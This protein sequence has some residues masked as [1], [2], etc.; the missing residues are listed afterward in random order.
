MLPTERP[1]G[2]A[3]VIL[4]MSPREAARRALVYRQRRAE[5]PRER[6]L[7]I[8]AFIGTL[9]VH[10]LVL[11]GAILGPA[12]DMIEPARQP[13]EPLQV[14]L[15]AHAPEPPPPP[16]PVHGLPPRQVGP[17]HHGAVTDT[18]VRMERSAAAPAVASRQPSPTP[19]PPIPVITV[20]AEP[21]TIKLAAPAAPRPPIR[22]PRPKPSR[23]LKPVPLAGE[24]PRFALDT[25]PA[26]VPVP[27]RFQPQP[28]RKPQPEG[29]QPMLSPTSLTL[30]A[31]H[32]R[33][34]PAV[35]APQIALDTT[36]PKPSDAPSTLTLVQP[37]APSVPSASELEAVPLPAQPAPQVD[38][39]PQLAALAPSVPRE[40]PQLQAPTVRLAEPELAAVPAAEPAP[41]ASVEPPR[42][43]SLQLEVPQ[44]PRPSLPS[45]ARPQLG[46]ADTSASQPAE[47][48]VK[49]ASSAEQ[50]PA[51]ASSAPST[52]STASTMQDTTPS[53]APE[54]APQGSDNAMPGRPEGV[55]ASNAPNLAGSSNGQPTPVPGNG[56]NGESRGGE[57]AGRQGDHAQ[58][59]A[60]EGAEHGRVGSYI[61]L[62][63]HGDAQIMDHRAP[64]IGY[65]PTRFEQDWTPEGESSI[66]T[67][68]RRA[69]DKT[70][71][72]HTFHL[73][74]GIRVECKLLPLMPVALFGCGNPDPPARPLADKV[75][76]RMHLAPANPL[77]PISEA[78]V[79]APAS[80]APPAPIKLDNSAE[81][82]A[83]RVAGGP[84]PPGC[85]SATS[86]SFKLAPASST[87]VPASDQF[88]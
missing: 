79:A 15:I 60:T 82:A 5:R 71:I 72:R 19:A 9:L 18:P 34:P 16:P 48:A 40:R 41:A 28:V 84:L 13:A 30:P 17:V 27:P 22:L 86:V 37:Q 12:Y 64:D 39:Q 4:Q 81:C 23:E 52:A 59:G 80:V 78:S 68:L 62:T 7:R 58:A 76:E 38:L 55:S 29:N 32:P 77:L 21:A 20:T 74:R 75:Y 73:P 53:S 25:P 67:A 2:A 56:R 14:R 65:R 66:D 36:P 3:K 24:P 44:A 11:L 33:A 8:A 63:P 43:P 88:H 54:A 31:L 51:M 83:A 49:A 46:A 61:Q 69:I 45:I 6:G 1:P 85:S 70:T 42:A 35:S 10:V 26:P 50:T 87:W 57:G 47:A